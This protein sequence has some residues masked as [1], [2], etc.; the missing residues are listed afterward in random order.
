MSAAELPTYGATRTPRRRPATTPALYL[1][2][3][4]A[5]A[6]AAL[7]VLPYYANG[8]DR[9]PLTEVASGLHDPKGLWPF[10][11]GALGGLLRLAAFCAMVACPL[12][13]ALAGVWA[14]IEMW[15]TRALPERR[16]TAVLGVLAIALGALTVVWVLSPMGEAFFAWMLD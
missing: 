1:A 14:G 11:L 5:A 8:L 16:R 2:A 10:D 4:S 13:A 9:F 15:R 3:G 12:V 7:F 6:L